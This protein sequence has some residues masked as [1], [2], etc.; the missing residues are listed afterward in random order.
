[1]KTF[2]SAVIAIYKLPMMRGFSPSVFTICL[3]LRF[4]LGKRFTPLTR[5]VTP[6]Y[7]SDR[8]VD[9]VIRSQGSA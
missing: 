4:V 1:M 3:P 6:E 5:F 8:K 2:V 7:F 9:R